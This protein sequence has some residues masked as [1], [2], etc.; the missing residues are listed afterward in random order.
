MERGN[1]RRGTGK[2]KQ[3]RYLGLLPPD[4][5]LRSIC[6]AI[7]LV[8]FLLITG[9]TAFGDSPDTY[10]LPLSPPNV[11]G[12][13][14]VTIWWSGRP[15][16]EAGLIGFYYSL[17]GSPF[18]FTDSNHVT[19]WN[20]TKGEH[21]LLV[22]SIDSTLRQDDQPAELSFRISPVVRGEPEVNDTPDLAVD[23]PLGVEMR[24]VSLLG[25]GDVDWYKVAFP[26]DATAATVTFRRDG[27]NSST[28]IS[29]YLNTPSEGNKAASFSV[30]VSNGER[31]SATVG[32]SPD[33]TLFIKV[34][35]SPDEKHPLYILSADYIPA[36]PHGI[37]EVEDNS[38]PASAT[39]L[40]L[41]EDRVTAIGMK[42]G[43]QDSSD[44][45][46]LHFDLTSPKLL[47]LNLSRLQAAGETSVQIF[48]GAIISDISQVSALSVSPLSNGWGSISFLVSFGDYYVR[49]S[50][51]QEGVGN[52]Y[53]ITLTLGDLPPG[54]EYEL[55]PNTV[56]PQENPDYVTPLGVEMG[57]YGYSWGDG[58]DDWFKF[59]LGRK[60]LLCLTLQRPEGIG[61]T[62]LQL[63]N[64][65]LIP[66][67][68]FQI[69]PST[70]QRG[71]LPV[72][73]A[74]PGTYY[75]KIVPSGERETTR[76]RLNALLIGSIEHNAQEPLGLGDELRV[77]VNWTA[78]REV[79]L[80]LEGDFQ[81][82][83]ARKRFERMPLSEVSPGRYELS[84]VLREGDSVENA[85]MLFTFKTPQG[86]EALYEYSE[87]ITLQAGKAIIDA[88]HDADHILKSGERLTVTL[89][90]SI[91][92]GTASF[93]I[94]G[95]TKD[96]SPLLRGGIPLYGDGRGNYSGSYVVQEGDLV[97]EGIVRVKLVDRFGTKYE[98][99]IKEPVSIDAV[100]PSPPS[101]LRGED[102]PEDNGFQIQL[103]WSLSPDPDVS[104]YNVYISPIPITSLQALSPI[105]RVKGRSCQVQV[106]R[107]GVGYYFAVTAVDMAG[108]ES[109]LSD[110]AIT[111]PVQA[112]DNLPPAAKSA[113]HDVTGIVSTLNPVINVKLQ[114]EPGI[115]PLLTIPGLVRDLPLEEKKDGVYT[116][117]YSVPKGVELRDVLLSL[118]LKDKAG[119][120]SSIDVPP[121]ITI[122][123]KPP[124][125]KSVKHDGTRLLVEGDEL[126]ITLEGEVGCQGWFDIEG[127]VKGIPLYDDGEHG[128]GAGGDGVYVGT[129]RVK[130]G[131]KAM[132]AAVVAHLKDK[133]GNE[134]SMEA[135]RKV[136]LDTT[137]PSISKAKVEGESFKL[138]D[139][140]KVE[141]WGEAGCQGKFRIEGLGV[142]GKLYDDG[143]HGDGEANDGMYVGSWKVGRGIGGEDLSVI[144][145]LEK[146]NGKSVQIEA[147][148]VKVDGVP[149]PE[150]EGVK[151]EDVPDDEGYRVRVSWQGVK[152]EDLKGYLVYLSSDSI[153]DLS[154]MSPIAETEKESVLLDVEE[155]G[156]QYHFA[157]VAEDEAGNISALGAGSVTVGD[158]LD[159]LAPPKPIDLKA[160]MVEGGRI[161]IGWE[162]PSLPADWAAFKVYI[163]QN[164]NLSGGEL[165][166]ITHNQVRSADLP[167]DK[168]GDYY[169]GLSAEDISGNESEII[170]IGPIRAGAISAMDERLISLPKGIIRGDGVLVWWRGWKNGGTKDFRYRLDGVEGEAEGP[171]LLIRSLT[172]GDHELEIELNGEVISRE[173]RIEPMELK[174]DGK[175]ETILPNAKLIGPG[176]CSLV[177]MR[178]ATLNL[179]GENG[180]VEV[181]LYR[182]DDLLME[183]QGAISLK[184]GI[185]RVETKGSV[186][187]YQSPLAADADME[188]ND[189][190]GFPLHG[191]SIISGMIQRKGDVDLY[192]LRVEGG[193][194]LAVTLISWGNLQLGIR[195]E[196]GTEVETDEDQDGGYRF[197]LSHPLSA[198]E[199]VI[200][201]KGDAGAIYQIGL[202]ILKGI[203]VDRRAMMKAGDLLRVTVD[204]ATAGEIWGEVKG[205]IEPVRL[206]GSGGL[207]GME[208]RIKDGDDL[209]DGRVRLEFNVSGEV[210]P[211][212]IPGVRINVDTVPPRITRAQHDAVKP[213]KA[214]DK[215]GI[216][217][218]GES[219]CEGWFEI[220]G[221]AEGIPLQ[222]KEAGRYEGEY[223]VREGD[224]TSDSDVICYLRDGAGNETKAVVK[225]RSG[226]FDK[227]VID[228]LPPRIDEVSYEGEGV[229]IEGQ[230][231]KVIVKGEAGCQ[232]WFDIGELRHDLPLEEKREGE[233]EGSYQVKM[234]DQALGVRIIA[235]LKDA[236]GNES[237]V[238]SRDALD[239]DT[240][241][242]QI[243]SVEHDATRTLRLGS[244]L[245]VRVKG[246]PGC[247]ARFSIE[248]VVED[249]PLGETGDGNYIGTYTVK[250]GDSADRAKVIVRLVKPNGKSASKSAS[251]RISIDTD[252]PEPVQGVTAA[253]KP[254]D[255]GFTLILSW[256][257]SDEPDFYA[258]RIYRSPTPILSTEELKPILELRSADITRTEVN[259]PE[260]DSDYYFAVT[261]V[262]E[263]GN[264]SKLSL[265]SGGSIFGPIRALDNLPPPPVTGVRAEDRP[266]DLGGVIVL[267]W[268]GPSPAEDFSRYNLYVSREPIA[269]TEGLNPI[270][271]PDRNVTAYEVQTADGVDYYFAVTAVDR[272]G[273]ESPLATTSVFGPVQSIPNIPQGEPVPGRIVAA[274]LGLS[275]SDAVIFHLSRWVP[276]P[277]PKPIPG[278]L[279]RLD[280]GSYELSASSHIAFFGLADGGHVFWAKPADRPD[281]QPIKWEFNVLRSPVRESEPNDTPETAFR[282][283]SG[284]P[285]V[286]TNS[287]DGDVDWF[288]IQIDSPGMLDITFGREKGIGRSTISIF[289]GLETAKAIDE[290]TVDPSTGGRGHSS[291]GVSPGRYL[292]R[293]IS[294]SENP[295]AEYRICAVYRELKPIYAWEVE[296]NDEW[297]AANAV[298]I[299]N[300]LELIGEGGGGDKDW[301][302]FTETVEGEMLELK[303]IRSGGKSTIRLIT[304]YGS[305]SEGGVQ[306]D[307]LSL[308]SDHAEAESWVGLKAGK[309]YM[310]IESPDKPP[311]FEYSLL[312]IKRKPEGSMEFEP[313]DKPDMAS[314]ISVDDVISCRTFSNGDV[315]L[316]ALQV[317]S[318]GSLA[319]GI[320]RAN[321]V[322]KTIA[323]LK[324]LDGTMIASA[325]ADPSN[326]GRASLNAEVNPGGYLLAVRT[327]NERPGDYT[328]TT[329]LVKS[330]LHDARKPLGIGDK[331]NVRI[332]WL[333]EKRVTLTLPKVIRDIEMNEE[334][335]GV[336]TASYTVKEG[337]TLSDQPY[338]SLFPDVSTSEAARLFLQPQ[339]LIDTMPP[340]I[341]EISHDGHDP[342]PLGG[343]LHVKLK[344]EPGCK[345]AYFEI[346]KGDFLRRVEMEEKEKGVYEGEYT[347]VSGDDVRGASVVGYLEDEVGNV[348]SREAFTPVTFDTLPPEITD[349]SVLISRGGGDFVPVDVTSD[350]VLGESDSLKVVI[351]SELNAKAEF[352]I[353]GFK[354]GLKL[355][356]DGAQGD[357][358]AGDGIYAGIYVVHRGDSIENT[359]IKVIVT[360]KAGNSQ[361]LYAPVT[362]TIDAVPP[363]IQEVT[364]NGDKPL[365]RGDLLVVKLKGEPGNRASF[366]INNRKDKKGKL[367]KIPMADDGTGYDETAGDGIYTGVYEVRP[368]DSIL[369]GSLIGFLADENGNESFKFSPKP[370]TL[371]STLP[372]PIEGLTAQDKPDDEGYVIILSWQPSKETD[373]DHYN[374]YRE[375]K[376]ISITRGL[377]PVLSN[378]TLPQMTTAEVPVPANNTDYYFAV[379]V[380]DK[381]GNESLI[382]D[383]SWV[384]PVQAWDNIKP[385]PVTKVTAE[386]YPDDQGKALLVKWDTPSAA[387]DF[388]HYNIYV[389]TTEIRTLNELKPAA[390][391]PNREAYSVKVEVDEDN[392]PY[393]VAVTAVDRNG[394]ESDLDALGNS[395][396]GPVQSLDNIPPQPVTGVYA[397]DTPGDE[398]GRITVV[399]S[400]E[401]D[402]SVIEH[403][404]YISSGQITPDE[405]LSKLE[406]ITVPVPAF[407]RQVDVQSDTAIY[408]AVTAV[409]SGENESKLTSDS[410]WGPVYA[411]SN[412]VKADRETVIYA[413]FDPR[414]RIKLPIGSGEEGKL[415]DIL[416]P[417]DPE[418][419]KRID[420]ANRL[421]A[422]DISLINPDYEEE[423]Q[424]TVIQVSY[425]GR[426]LSKP[427]ELTLSY[428]EFTDN[429]GVE[430]RVRIF[431]LNPSSTT[432]VWELLPGRQVV[433]TIRNTVTASTDT[434]SAF[435]V[436][437]LNLPQT[438]DK[439]K[440]Y[441]NPYIYGRSSS[442]RITF[443]N[444]PE[445]ATIQIYTL[446]G[447]LVRTIQVEPMAG[448]ASWDLKNEAGRPVGGGIYVYLVKGETGKA[449]GRIVILK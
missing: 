320:E 384:G 172:P 71:S 149:P 365:R 377:I 307:E 81:D 226:E 448:R 379:T 338:V 428:P 12:H 224:N 164:P 101:E 433:D 362:I 406:F 120:E 199:Y 405:D 422:L 127:L 79:Y 196:R 371:D 121:P 424:S 267:R 409:D 170:R 431:R 147:G 388:D 1:R 185:Y 239:I 440:V 78:G 435:R 280:D 206:S 434:L 50:N 202:I 124:Q 52:T 339:I 42:N 136:N 408:V 24:G 270:K 439:V 368:D 92:D 134:S 259:V 382:R 317:K 323:E 438:L 14:D 204:W 443:V 65:N 47:R 51:D 398:G 35:P 305:P 30:N 240:I 297:M 13:S 112:L 254:L 133:A 296:P 279:Y 210:I 145:I 129:Y 148:S 75:V 137:P 306:V 315:D 181:K 111:G 212:E 287:D 389:S 195:D 410:V 430:R 103:S 437:V 194:R 283:S 277:E 417:E 123:T 89:T 68:S 49:V 61:Q 177:L 98:F 266:S 242:P 217:V 376:R 292:V 370:L 84:Y 63:F 316:Y 331:L 247:D 310:L 298:R 33:S 404:I 327:E 333:P 390:S 322:G 190:D 74:D 256:D 119:N 249:L 36:S 160:E 325:K 23:L 200:E 158:A 334:E 420:E 193:E 285:V 393:Y 337:D 414:I 231:L 55:E 97:R 354:S 54:S 205:L 113:S 110:G 400:P 425:T 46:K 442:G 397:Y 215:I 138:G 357:E 227:V 72:P 188:P 273:N 192:R 189:E 17:D 11:I 342:I 235:H 355:R 180:G 429:A 225:G 255:E 62:E 412:R 40:S 413:G 171:Y 232:A 349:L 261:A 173:F 257:R 288:S 108:N 350:R 91:T 348:S 284:Q 56:S 107:N 162:Y 90:S 67:S 364:H 109:D 37:W 168:D 445:K 19:L 153:G 386:D 401:K 275:L 392:V 53:Q 38:S 197:Y 274:P 311:R 221:I 152:V 95:G 115:T 214:G 328:I 3:K 69:S 211:F 302:T 347:V 358:V 312:L 264:E 243:E 372:E 237:V 186:T 330:A 208:Y 356:D 150:V 394:N 191:D 27:G 105:A 351:R 163:S 380:V 246:T 102:V 99:E 104:E 252:P 156:R 222:E 154:T 29:L 26:Q 155:N 114:S 41:V 308:D 253:D 6:R 139:V 441:P 314:G 118:K 178:D 375:T 130:T 159:N 345:L 66:I 7:T 174:L 25:G 8:T 182:D 233:Y 278:Y 230:I 16:D 248:G 88:K 203:G 427:A 143:E 309:Y 359:P 381:A 415:L 251:L 20:L 324:R 94:V 34:A 157:V 326:E 432:G 336:Y 295:A 175:K 165:V 286:G 73:D 403:R 411:V 341:E 141:L 151:V 15:S 340:G 135:V 293:V 418:I 22:K 385:D 391:E 245:T 332:E 4:S 132:E 70:S 335:P 43:D 125:I 60:G 179:V 395:T 236:A 272:S 407:E 421:S 402:L 367:V 166:R 144:A 276:S 44:W 299:D 140:V 167:A 2:R 183:G 294:K 361:E 263:A 387:E 290:F 218:G 250:E 80:T 399:W 436:A 258:Y 76:Y 201:V 446:T 329:A 444:L 271:V 45:Y 216:E 374:V 396:W 313:N 176:T 447:E 93:D 184:A 198:G 131:D 344:G 449:R 363:K 146:S 83:E 416:I 343:T 9:F 269:S 289:H 383:G 301:F 300:A 31:G 128:D 39:R 87:R 82:E 373:F 238:E 352:E 28:E 419:L 85:R 304:F 360:D 303:L 229:L 122:D 378:L 228:T 57:I 265:K 100:K 209:S 318:H 369:N 169:I 117:S 187:I 234:G 220:T 244:V 58:D 18:T 161:Y 262:D 32:I 291:V 366:N 21:R 10:I 213:L 223:Q 219:G 282:L 96:P 77:A 106:E 260:N 281:T 126:K 321:A 353:E 241:P 346:R 423:L 142:E 5:S 426:R 48:K 59:N 268:D 319:I 64:S 116:I 86:D 207:M